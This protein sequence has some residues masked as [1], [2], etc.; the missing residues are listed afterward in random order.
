MRVFTELLEG[1]RFAGE[2]IWA[3]K[4]R[5]ALTTLGIVVGIVTVTLMGMAIEGLNRAFLGSISALG[6]DVLYVQRHAWFSEEDWWKQRNRRD[7]TL[8]QSRAVARQLDL[9]EAVV[10][11]AEL[12][13]PVKYRDRSAA[14]VWIVGNTEDSALVRGLAV[15]EGRFLSAAEVAGARPVCVLGGDLAERFFPLESPLG[16]RV[17]IGEIN[18]EVV[19]VIEKKGQLFFGLNFDNQIIIPIS[20]FASDFY[21]RPGVSVLVKLR[22]L[23]QREETKEELRG[24][25]RKVRRLAPGQPDDFAINEQ[26]I[27]IRTFQRVGGT[28]A[29]VGLFITGLALFVGG[30][31]IMNIMFV[32]VAERTREIGVRKALGAKRRAILLQFL[33]EAAGICLLGGALGLGLAWLASLAIQKALPT[34]M[35]PTVAAAALSISAITGIIAGSLPAWRA[36]RM[37]PVNALRSE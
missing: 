2:A 7:I 31:G 21:W 14:G 33:T 18:Y 9:A 5:A 37:D 27:L 22:D 11:Q 15:K 19:G 25:M 10:P 26:E 1:L 30:I 20:R 24:V 17:Q 29:S 8:A 13:R 6:A 23:E 28:I 36:A 16:K 34:A 4:L 32:S 35:S 3:N 12:F